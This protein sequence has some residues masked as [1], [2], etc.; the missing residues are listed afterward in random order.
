MVDKLKTS[1]IVLI[2]AN[3]KIN[4]LKYLLIRYLKN[5]IKSPFSLFTFLIF[6]DSFS[7]WEL[8]TK[9]IKRV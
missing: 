7:K 1:H 4:Q 6:K 5:Y 8:Q 9:V 2:A 3:L